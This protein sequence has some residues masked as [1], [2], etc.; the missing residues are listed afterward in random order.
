VCCQAAELARVRGALDAAAAMAA[1][2]LAAAPPDLDDYDA[3]ADEHDGDAIDSPPHAA[4]LVAAVP[5]T[6]ASA[7]SAR[8]RRGGALSA[9][10]RPTTL[11]GAGGAGAGGAGVTADVAAHLSRLGEPHAAGALRAAVRAL[12]ARLG[13][14]AARAA[15]KDSRLR[16]AT[17]ALADKD[18]DCARL[19]AQAVR[20][21]THACLSLWHV[22]THTGGPFCHVINRAS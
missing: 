3:D 22:I 18:A 17:L 2:A 14:A 1:A 4:A 10:V 7:A 8:A 12:A 9:G 20:S 6:P 5:D 15:V 16:A 19:E 13:R 21:N 11:F